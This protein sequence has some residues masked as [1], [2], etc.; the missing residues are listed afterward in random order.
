MQKV[1]VLAAATML[2]AACTQAQEPEATTSTV[3]TTSTTAAPATTMP[4]TPDEAVARFVSCMSEQGIDLPEVEVDAQGRPVLGDVLGD[5]DTGT[6][7]FRGAIATCSS[8]LTQAG[9]L[10]LSGD[11]ELQAV[12]V[13]QLASFAECMRSEGIA[14]FPD[15]DQ[16]FDGVGS[17]FPLELIPINDPGFADATLACQ[18]QLGGLALAPQAP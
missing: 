16:D 6:V 9:V 7:E 4:L 14:E 5:V 12:V 2:M 10:D 1:G 18:D 8:I 17:P 15:P 3:A 13:E 11:P